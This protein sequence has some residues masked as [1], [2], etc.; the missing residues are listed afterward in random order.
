MEFLI[1]R[2]GYIVIPRARYY[3]YRSMAGRPLD[4]RVEQTVDLNTDYRL[5]YQF[6]C[7]V[8]QPVMQ[9]FMSRRHNQVCKFIE[10]E[11]STD[12]CTIRRHDSTMELITIYEL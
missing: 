8:A 4:F 2:P 6:Y 12:M 1:F 7:L 11:G 10:K 3:R 9:I 5:P